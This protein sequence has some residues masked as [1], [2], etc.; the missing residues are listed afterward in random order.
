[1]VNRDL[2]WHEKLAQWF[3]VE[4][5]DKK[6][7]IV[8]S[9]RRVIKGVDSE[10]KDYAVHYYG[11]DIWGEVA[12]EVG[13]LLPAGF[14][15]YAEIVGYTSDGDMIQKGYHYGCRPGTHETY[16]YRVTFTNV[17]GHVFE[18]PWMQVKAFCDKYGFK[19]V[20][21]LYYGRACDLHKWEQ[22]QYHEDWLQIS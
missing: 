8:W 10:P 14:T 21:E 11:S 17:D 22:G 6:Y 3:G 13:P 15:V 4:V 9:S 12:K 19:F 7:G 2:K 5:N 16:V 18:L 1:M 20:P